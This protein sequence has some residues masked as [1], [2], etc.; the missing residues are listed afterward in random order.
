MYHYLLY[1]LKVGSSRELPGPFVAIDDDGA[2]LSVNWQVHNEAQILLPTRWEKIEVP[3]SRQRRRLSFFRD[4]Q[5]TDDSQLMI[6]HTDWLGD[7]YCTLS[8]DRRSLHISYLA[9]VDFTDICAYFCGSIIGFVLRLRGHLCLHASAV[10]VDGAAMLFIGPK[11]AGKSSF[12]ASMIYENGA[13]LVADDMAVIDFAEQPLIRFAYPGLRINPDINS[14]FPIAG[15]D[16]SQPVY[17]FSQKRLIALEYP[18]TAG[19]GNP[20]STG[21]VPIRNVF[22]LYRGQNGLLGMPTITKVAQTDAAAR[23]ATQIY[24]AGAVFTPAAI[25]E[26]FASVASLVNSV[27]VFTIENY[28]RLGELKEIGAAIKEGRLDGPIQ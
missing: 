2:S 20:V 14:A 25:A 8:P 19:T 12:A 9:S 5:R 26:E 13:S 1:G 15:Y 22:L 18:A 21:P 23:L 27:P 6:I 3:S 11:G 17:S 7:I 4:T 10:A 16:A 24:G 28:S